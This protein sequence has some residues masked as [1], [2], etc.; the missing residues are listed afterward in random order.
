[1]SDEKQ[2]Y[3][4]APSLARAWNDEGRTVLGRAVILVLRERSSLNPDPRVGTK[5][6]ASA[7][8]PVATTRVRSLEDFLDVPAFRSITP[9]S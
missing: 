4:S 3:P 5:R 1:M 9:V 6:C 7:I 8:L 2:G